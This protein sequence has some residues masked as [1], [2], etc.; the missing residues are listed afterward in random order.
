MPPCL[1]PE[2]RPVQRDAAAG[3]PKGRGPRRRPKPCRRPFH[4]LG[5]NLAA[6]AHCR[7]RATARMRDAAQRPVP[8]GLPQLHRAVAVL[9][10]Q[11]VPQVGAL[12]GQGKSWSQWSR[13]S[14]RA[15]L[16]TPPSLL[17][18]FDS[19]LVIRNVTRFQPSEMASNMVSPDDTTLLYHCARV[20]APRCRP[21]QP[22]QKP[23]FYE[24]LKKKIIGPNIVPVV[25]SL[26]W[27]GA[28]S[29]R[30]QS[31]F[32]SVSIA[33]PYETESENFPANLEVL[34]NFLKGDFSITEIY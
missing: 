34:P 2:C 9:A 14:P 22:R 11:Q 29:P 16:L 30:Q 6:S 15:R 32:A 8:R 7:P 20:S 19:V 25:C 3:A 1:T 28:S 18:P 12:C 21:D 10:G 17:Q 31:Q 13:L 4:P 26:C 24:D 5:P 27:E 33:R 23:R